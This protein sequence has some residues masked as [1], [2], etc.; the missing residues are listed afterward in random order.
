M[1]NCHMAA[2]G[3]VCKKVKKQFC[4]PGLKRLDKL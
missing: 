4:N 1:R 2:V 3:D